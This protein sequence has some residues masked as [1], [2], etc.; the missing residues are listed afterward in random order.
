MRIYTFRS[1]SQ[2]VIRRCGYKFVYKLCLL[3]MQVDLGGALVLRIPNLLPVRRRYQILGVLGYYDRERLYTHGRRR[4]FSRGTKKSFR[5]G[6]YKKRPREGGLFSKLRVW[7]GKGLKE[8]FFLRHCHFWAFF[9]KKRNFFKNLAV[10]FF[11]GQG[12]ESPVKMSFFA[13]LG[14]WSI[15]ASGRGTRF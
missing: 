9:F 5:E 4:N 3:F 12:G 14:G 7:V 6:D 11:M 15:F 1:I 10:F 8:I 2:M 13:L